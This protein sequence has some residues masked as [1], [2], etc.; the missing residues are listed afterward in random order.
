MIHY[1]ELG[2][3]GR[4][5]VHFEQ[6]LARN[7]QRAL[8]DLGSV[9]VRRFFSYLLLE[10]AGDS[11]TTLLEARL[12]A[13]FGIAY[14]APVVETQRD[15]ESISEAAIA[16]TQGR[17]TAQTTFR[18]RTTRGDKQY[19]LKSIEV[20]REVGGRIV[21]LTHAPVKLVDPDITL[22]IQI[23]Q[24]GAYL[25]IDRLQGAGG[26]PYGSSGRVLALFSGGIDSPVAAHL[27]MKRGCAVD[28]LHFHLLP[29]AEEA[30]QSKITHLARTILAPHRQPAYLY[31]VSAAP[32]EAAMV[33]MES[34]EATV[35]FR[36]FII[37]V[38]QVIAKRRKALALVMGDS[39]GQVAS[40]TLQNIKVISQATDLPILRPLV[41]M[42]KLEIVELA[43]AIGTYELS[44]EPYRDPCSLHVQRPA[45]WA[46]LEPVLALEDKINVDSLVQETL[47]NYV[48][49]VRIRFDDAPTGSV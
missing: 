1:G 26:L 41:G 43:Q 47:T 3:K 19:P 38:A 24:D 23:Y 40:Q 35:V 29:S 17:V 18:V 20:D 32:F 36:R 5:R 4:N 16:L 21:E 2:L 9:K 10:Y 34:R 22:H 15:I 31:L 42:D 37:R 7:I 6:Q 27:M 33:L 11:P 13:V 44:I 46:R 12:R 48:T 25:F 30:R 14:F 49:K 39:V 45:T 28:F 8:S